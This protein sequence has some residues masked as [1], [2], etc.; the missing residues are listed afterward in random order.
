MDPHAIL[1]AARACRASRQMT[2]SPRVRS[3]CTSHGVIAPVSM[4]MQDSSPACRRTIAAICSGAVGH[5]PRHSLRPALST[6]QMAVI[7]CET[8]K[9][10]KWVIMIEPPMVRITERRRPDRGT[11]ERS[12]AHRD[13]RMSTHVKGFGCRPPHA[14]SGRSGAGDRKPP[15]E[16]TAGRKGSVCHMARYGDLKVAVSA[17]GSLFRGLASASYVLVCVKEAVLLICAWIFLTIVGLE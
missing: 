6:T 16:E 13:Y 12:G 9:P 7:F 11:I 4:P 10:T 1:R 15:W 8:S 5:W 17:N 3:S 2:S 14:R